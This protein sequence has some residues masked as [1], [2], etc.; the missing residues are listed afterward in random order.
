MTDLNLLDP[1]LQQKLDQERLLIMLR[2]YT[3]L[4]LAVVATIGIFFVLSRAVLTSNFHDTVERMNIVNNRNQPVLRA[5][6]EVNTSLNS[7]D[8]IQEEYRPWSSW[9]EQFAAIV[10]AGNI[11]KSLSIEEATHAVRIEGT[12]ET[13]DD[14]LR[15]KERLESSGLVEKVDFP[16][17]NLL[18]R[19]NIDFG[20]SAKYVMPPPQQ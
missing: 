20:L 5:I 15:L 3:T 13:R 11:I 10:A 18:L 8:T 19:A 9:L 7:L 1:Q 14:L 17:S 4:I 2:D 12:S 16:L 6:R